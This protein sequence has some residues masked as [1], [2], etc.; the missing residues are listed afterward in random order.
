MVHIII[1]SFITVSVSG[2]G[3]KSDEVGELEEE[4]LEVKSDEVGELEEELEE[5]E[6][7]E[8]KSDEVGELEEELE[9]KS[10]EVGEL[11]EVLFLSFQSVLVKSPFVTIC[12]ATF[13]Y[14]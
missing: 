9:V 7:L 14:F 4:E 8:V 6:E 2:V 11:E 5:L 1:H 13:Y 12:G 10:D 3:V